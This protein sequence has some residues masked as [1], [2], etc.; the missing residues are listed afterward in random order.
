MWLSG[1]KISF[2]VCVFLSCS[3]DLELKLFFF[4]WRSLKG[5]KSSFTHRPLSRA[6][7]LSGLHIS[8]LNSLQV[9]QMTASLLLPPSPHHL[10]TIMF[11]I[12]P[13]TSSLLLSSLPQAHS[14]KVLPFPAGY[15]SVVQDKALWLAGPLYRYQ[16]QIANPCQEHSHCWLS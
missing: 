3:F 5:S 11:T 4:F 10:I 13:G 6:L 2:A 8:V 1:Y 12:H 14:L 7:C 9:C 15:R 16:K